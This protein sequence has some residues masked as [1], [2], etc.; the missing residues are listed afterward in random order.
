MR[1]KPTVVDFPQRL[2]KQSFLRFD[3]SLMN[4]S[5]LSKHSVNTFVG[6]ALR[7]F[8]SFFAILN[9][10]ELITASSN[11]RHELDRRL[12]CIYF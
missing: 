4:S 6:G 1:Y 5:C 12:H 8:N 3:G 7:F 10:I 9:A 2:V 11:D